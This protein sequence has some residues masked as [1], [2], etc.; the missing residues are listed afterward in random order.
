MGISKTINMPESATIEDIKNAY[1][2]AWKSKCKGITV[3][4]NNSRKKQDTGSIEYECPECGSDLIHTGGC[5]TCT[6]GY[7]ICSM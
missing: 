4:R 7:G 1:M 6:C 2:M 5:I 3:Y